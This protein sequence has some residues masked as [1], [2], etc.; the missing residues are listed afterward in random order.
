[1]VIAVG[2]GTF[3][4]LQADVARQQAAI[5]A[6]REE[7]ALLAEDE[8]REAGE[9][10]GVAQEQSEQSA[11]FAR[12]RELIASAHAALDEDPAL[13]K[14]LAVAS[15]SLVEPDLAMERALHQVWSADRVIDRISWPDDD[16]VFAGLDTTGQLILKSAPS[17]GSEPE[18]V[19]VIDRQGH[20]TLWQFEPLPQT[21]VGQAFFSTDGAAII[22]STFWDPGDDAPQ[23][24]DPDVLGLH[25]WEART[26]RLLRHFDV[27][28]CGGEVGAIS[29]KWALVWS[30]TGEQ[31][32]ASDCFNDVPP[33]VA[34]I[35]LL[36]GER[37]VVAEGGDDVALSRDGDFLAMTDQESGMAV[38]LEIESER[39]VMAFDGTT[40]RQSD[41]LYAASVRT[42]R[43]SCTAT[44]Q[45][46]SGTRRPARLSGH[47]GASVAR[48]MRLRSLQTGPYSPLPATAFCANTMQQSAPRFWSSLLSA[49]TRCH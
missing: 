21:T 13:A 1:M 44:G 15:A 36:T 47:S 28:P 4:F 14:L 16:F 18:L 40:T 5:A 30:S 27:G 12:S 45:F 24:P 7:Q 33:P 29:A 37:R 10:A 46:R 41:H 23:P 34:L 38:V 11:V 17:G 43:C 35:D 25:I 20:Q 6:E 3:A 31:L 22:A 19:E 42:A 32:T 2:A 26:G 48:A 39:R 8:A 9:Q 49:A